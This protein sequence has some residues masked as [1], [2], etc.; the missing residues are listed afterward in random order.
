MSI[1]PYLIC[2]WEKIGAYSVSGHTGY[3]VSG[4]YRFAEYPA[5]SV[6]GAS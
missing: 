6:S 4:F 2:Y 1:L 5:K 3:L